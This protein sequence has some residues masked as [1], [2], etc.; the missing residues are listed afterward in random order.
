MRMR[1]RVWIISIATALFVILAGATAAPAALAESRNVSS[2]GLD[3]LVGTLTSPRVQV[4]RS[5]A[6]SRGS[7]STPRPGP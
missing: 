1:A 2:G 6:S 3:A 5:F 7:G 4:V